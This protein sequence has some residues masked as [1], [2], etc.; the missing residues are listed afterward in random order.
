MWPPQVQPSALQATS[1]S[2]DKSPSVLT[3]YAVPCS[4]PVPVGYPLWN[5]NLMRTKMPNRASKTSTRAQHILRVN[6]LS[7]SRSH[8]TLDF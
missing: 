1:G 8:P 3:Y 6:H 2:T 4:R 5:S 7:A